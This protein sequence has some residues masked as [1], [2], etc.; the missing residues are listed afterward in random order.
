MLWLECAWALFALN[1][2]TYNPWMSALI[3][4]VSVLVVA[5]PCALGL[6]TPTAIIVG[7]GKGAEQGILIKGGES[8]ERMQAIRAVMLDKTGTIT[9]GKPELTDVLV[10][11]GMQEDEL[12]RLVAQAEQGSEHPLAHAIITGTRARGIHLVDILAM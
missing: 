3:A 8:L 10:V 6:A 9:K 5:C 7:T 1:M 12:L 11:P 2:S 4:A